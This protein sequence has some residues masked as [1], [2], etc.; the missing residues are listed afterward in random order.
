M[1]IGGT[2]SGLASGTL[3]GAGLALA[4]MTNPNKVLNFLDVTGA[5][6]PSLAFVM[7]SAIPIA[8]LGFWLARA[9]AR[10]LL[11]Q[12][13]IL[14]QKSRLEPSLLFGAALFGVGWGLGGYC[15]GPAVASLGRPSPSLLGFLAA[16]CLGLLLAPAVAKMGSRGLRAGPGAKPLQKS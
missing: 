16:M 9:R 11:T 2:V 12:R 7:L 13:F 8:A 4:G 14:P 15:P 1:S 3:F 6:D 10:P 5:W